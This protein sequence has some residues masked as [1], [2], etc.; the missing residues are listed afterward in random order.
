M[1][2]LV[3]STRLRR[4]QAGITD[5]APIRLCKRN[6]CADQICDI[7]LVYR[8]RDPTRRATHQ[9]SLITMSIRQIPSAQNEF[10]RQAE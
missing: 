7:N 3:V 10:S 4:S 5:R 6:L 9:L 8:R 1:V 2:Q